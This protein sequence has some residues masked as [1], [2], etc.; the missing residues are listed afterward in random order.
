MKKASSKYY[1]VIPFLL[2]KSAKW[3]GWN[4]CDCYFLIYAS[5]HF[6]NF[7][8]QHNAKSS[9]IFIL[10]EACQSYLYWQIMYFHTE[11]KWCHRK[12]TGLGEE[13]SSSPS[14]TVHS[15]ESL[16]TSHSTSGNLG[17]L[18][19]KDGGTSL[20]TQWLGICLPMQ[21]TRVS[22]LVQEDPTCRAATKPA[23]H[24]YW[25]HVPQLLKSVRLEPMLLNKRGHCDEACAP[26]WGGAPARRN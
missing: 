6:P 2:R 7:Q 25:T 5:L 12:R 23:N 26:Q 1:N 8:I 19:Y 10:F 24:N 16:W 18:I 20:V 21:G 14:F 15:S 11:A 22:A 13:L 9:F 17:S 3:W 4:T